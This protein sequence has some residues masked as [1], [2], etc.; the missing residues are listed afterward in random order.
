MA[1]NESKTLTFAACDTQAPTIASTVVATGDTR[2][3]VYVTDN[4]GTSA[5]DIS[6][7]IS[8]SNTKI[9]SVT[10][11]GVNQSGTITNDTTNVAC[12][13]TPNTPFTVGT[14]VVNLTATDLAGNVGS[15]STSFTVYESL[16]CSASP[17]MIEEGTSTITASG[18]KS[19]YTAVV[20]SDTTGGATLTTGSSP[21]TL[22]PGA[23]AGTVAVRI[24]D[25]Q[26]PARTCDVSVTYTP[27]ILTVAATKSAANGEKISVA[28]NDGTPPYVFELTTIAPTGAAIDP[29]SGDYLAPSVSD[30]TVQTET[31]LAT[32]L[33]SCTGTT[34][35]KIAASAITVTTEVVADK[36][37]FSVSSGTAASSMEGVTVELLNSCGSVD[38]SGVYTAPSGKNC[39]ASVKISKGGEWAKVFIQ[40][41]EGILEVIEGIKV[42]DI[43]MDTV[44]NVNDLTPV[45]DWILK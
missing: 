43:N 10:K 11:G 38:S 9:T 31:I 30:S 28:A 21:W 17:S 7:T 15:L 39:V 14:Y 24:T 6:E 19:P 37:Y 13:F 34:T 36:V 45:I 33:H 2:V 27:C 23:T 12:I 3:T 32:D 44:V 26:T 35:V 18:G 41:K 22:T 1:S 5:V 20:N 25:S 29:V 42:E 16:S 8:S 4:S 40:V